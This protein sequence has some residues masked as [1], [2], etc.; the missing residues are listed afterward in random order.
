MVY[1]GRRSLAHEFMRHEDLLSEK[2]KGLMATGLDISF[3]EYR[4]AI[5]LA[6]QCRLSLRR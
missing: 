3:S 6:D 1:E 2:L 4:Q 5:D